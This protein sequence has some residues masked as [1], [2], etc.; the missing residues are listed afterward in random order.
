MLLTAPGSA[1]ALVD[2]GYK[3]QNTHKHLLKFDIDGMFVFAGHC[4]FTAGA[5]RIHATKVHSDSTQELDLSTNILH[6]CS[7]FEYVCEYS[8]SV[9]LNRTSNCVEREKSLSS[10]L[11][12]LNLI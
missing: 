1:A 6:V 10:H 8:K 3:N 11:I 7:S 5:L 2:L 9:H 4:R 12:H